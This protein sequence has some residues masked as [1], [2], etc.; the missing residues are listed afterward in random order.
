M[1]ELKLRP[2]KKRKQSKWQSK[3]KRKSKVKSA[4]L[5]TGHHRNQ[6]V[7]LLLGG[8]HGILQ[9]IDFGAQG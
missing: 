2:P 9:T 1:S 7:R 8:G 4:G 6:N 5:K 3:S